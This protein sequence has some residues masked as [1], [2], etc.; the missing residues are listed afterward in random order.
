MSDAVCPDCRGAGMTVRVWCVP[1]GRFVHAW[2]DAARTDP[3]ERVQT[4]CGHPGEGTLHVRPCRCRSEG[5]REAPD[6]RDWH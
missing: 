5:M 4:D 2:E 3:Q 1:C 6:P